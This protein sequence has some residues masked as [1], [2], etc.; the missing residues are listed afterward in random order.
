MA[1]L[2]AGYIDKAIY[3]AFTQLT[4]L[5][6]QLKQSQ[7]IRKA[8]LNGIS[9]SSLVEEG[10]AVTGGVTADTDIHIAAYRLWQ[11]VKTND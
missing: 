7:N 8:S 1:R 3:P 10:A 9:K 6:P 5:S 4:P 2:S 11:S